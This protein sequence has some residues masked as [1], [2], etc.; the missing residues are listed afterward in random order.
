MHWR[1]LPVK[2]KVYVIFMYG[3]ALPLA[4]VTLHK[5][6][7]YGLTWF[8]FTLASLFVATI[9]VNLPQLP[10]VVVSMGDVFTI[11]ALIHFGAAPALLT[12]WGNVIV[13]ALAGHI[14]RHGFRLFGKLAPHRLLFNIS[15]CAVSIYVMSRVYAF[16]GQFL[17]YPT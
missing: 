4:F 13:T 7:Q 16:T 3:L 2:C 10:S 15:C 5:G 11:L 12:Y 6:G 1:D 8:L 9:N 17:D 14:K